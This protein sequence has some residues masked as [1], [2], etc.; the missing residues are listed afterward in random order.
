MTGDK[1]V[2]LINEWLDLAKEVGDMNLNRMEYDEERYN[3][4]MDRMDVIRQKI[5]D[6]H[7]QMFSEDEGD[8]EWDDNFDLENEQMMEEQDCIQ[9]KYCGVPKI[10]KPCQDCNK[11]HF[12]QFLGLEGNEDCFEEAKDINSKII[13]SRK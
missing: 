4:A 10:E 12:Y 7:E 9:C 1:A 13:D 6:Y 2:E 5:N 8:E 3:Y 11:N